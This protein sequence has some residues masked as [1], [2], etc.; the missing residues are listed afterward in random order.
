MVTMETAPI[1][2]HYYYYYI[3]I[4]GCLQCNAIFRNLA[5]LAVNWIDDVVYWTDAAYD[6]IFRYKGTGSCRFDECVRTVV[7]T[8]LDTPTGLA[9]HPHRQ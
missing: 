3:I 8:D 5:A 2:V 1:K 6:A 4:T 9:V 7:S